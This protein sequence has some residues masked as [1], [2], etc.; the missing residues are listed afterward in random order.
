MEQVTNDVL[1]ERIDGLEKRLF[2][3]LDA[4]EKQTIKTNGRT[5]ASETKINE[6]DG[7]INKFIGGLIV[8]DFVLAAV[9]AIALTIYKT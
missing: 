2:D 9:L 5:T 6:L 7:K 3:K 4:I 8:V 1:A